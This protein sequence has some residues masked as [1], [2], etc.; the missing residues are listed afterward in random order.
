MR[1][2]RDELALHARCC[3][4]KRQE[5]SKMNSRDIWQWTDST[6]K[7]VPHEQQGT[8]WNAPDIC[9]LGRRLKCFII[10]AGQSE[11]WVQNKVLIKNEFLAFNVHMQ[12]ASQMGFLY[13]RLNQT[14]KKNT[15]QIK[16]LK[17]ALRLEC[18]STVESSG[19]NKQGRATLL[20]ATYSM[21]T[22]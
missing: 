17:M 5:G 15:R 20:S 3:L 14:Q 6:Q 1:L 9:V 13:L 7:L 2:E 19:T 22:T 12:Y 4:H 21:N 8:S 10:K 16:L 18:M 11:L